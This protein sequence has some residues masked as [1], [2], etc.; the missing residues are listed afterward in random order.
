M[1]KFLLFFILV[2]SATLSAQEEQPGIK[3]RIYKKDEVSVEP[4]FPGGISVF[5]THVNQN[6]V[7]PE[8]ARGTIKIMVS[9][10]IEKDG[11]MSNFEVTGKKVDE[12]LRKETIRVL[13]LVH[14]YWIPARLNDQPVRYRYTFPI[15][16]NIS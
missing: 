3:D 6:F 12:G 16:I 10:V 13:Q 1:K 11:T 7:T 8:N 14:Q 5:Y 15:M 2:F 9:C 4:Q